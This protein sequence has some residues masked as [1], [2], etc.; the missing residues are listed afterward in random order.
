MLKDLW[1]PIGCQDRQANPPRIIDTPHA[2]T[3]KHLVMHETQNTDWY[4]SCFVQGIIPFDACSFLGLRDFLPDKSQFR[5]LGL[6][7]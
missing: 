3:I 7:F 6:D 1:N 5:C 2:T 4:T